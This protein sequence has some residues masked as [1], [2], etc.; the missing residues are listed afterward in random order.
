VRY[1][2][3][4]MR[5]LLNREGWDVGKYLVYR[6]YT[7]EGLTLKRMKPAGRRKASRTR[8]DRIK[9]TAPSLPVFLSQ[10]EIQVVV[11]AEEIGP[12]LVNDSRVVAGIAGIGIHKYA[13]YPRRSS[14]IQS[15]P[16]S[17]GTRTLYS[18]SVGSY[19]TKGLPGSFQFLNRPW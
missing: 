10:G 8:E 18:N 11:E 1:G 12:S 7:E 17:N 2:Y 14:H 9:P 4:K 6:L 5:V 13:L 3:R 15:L 19:G 16:D